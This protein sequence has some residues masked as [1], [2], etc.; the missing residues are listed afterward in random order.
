VRGDQGHKGISDLYRLF[1]LIDQ[2][3]GDRSR[4]FADDPLSLNSLS[5][6]FERQHGGVISQGMGIGESVQAAAE[7]LDHVA[8]G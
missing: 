5:N 8:G 4:K 6:N 2:G 7:R 3:I 1:K